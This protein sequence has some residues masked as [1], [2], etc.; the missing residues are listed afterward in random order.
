MM[1]FSGGVNRE[2]AESICGFLDISLSQLDITR[3]ADG[4]TRVQIKENVRGK[5]VFIVQSTCCPAN[6][7]LMELMIIMDAIRRAS[8][9]RI[10]AVIPYFGYARQDRKDKSRVPITA[11]LVANLL[12]TAGAN[13]ILTIDLHADQIQGFF[14]IPLDHLFASK[15]LVEHLKPLKTEKN[16]VVVS[17][18]VGGSKMARSYANRLQCPWAIVDKGRIDDVNTEVINVMGNVKGRVAII[19]DD[20]ISTASSLVEASRAVLE[21]GASEVY[22]AITHPV[23][24]GPAM[25]RLQ[26][27]DIKQLIVTDTIPLASEK[28]TPRIIVLSVASL[29]AEAIK[30]IH[31]EKSISVLFD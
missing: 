3:F 22:A 27:S 12:T 30:R 16:L 5:D 4:E 26:N 14:D 9:R 2:L 20:V 24:C 21:V 31:E 29:L 10:T 25:E 19:V 1:V 15:I 8:A 17:S 13:R 7:N 6:E 28:K 23:L 11:K 18:D